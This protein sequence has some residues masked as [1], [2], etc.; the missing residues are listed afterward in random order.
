[1]LDL[2]TADRDLWDPSHSSN[3]LQTLQT[4]GTGMV[5]LR[6]CSENRADADII[7]H[8]RVSRTRIGNRFAGQANHHI[9]TYHLAHIFRINVGLSNMNTVR[10]N[11]D[12]RLDI[13]IDNQGHASAGKKAT[14]RLTDF[15]K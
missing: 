12:R 9:R 13:I 5:G 15:N 6:R 1:M 2:D 3:V 14:D 8:L 4:N 10:A 11:C 7:D